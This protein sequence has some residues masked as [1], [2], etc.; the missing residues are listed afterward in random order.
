MHYFSYYGQLSSDFGLV[1]SEKNIYSAPQRDMEFVSVP[2]RN[3]DILIDH[4]RF[5]NLEV[6]YTVS[7]K[8]AKEKAPAIRQW[9]TGHTGYTGLMDSYQPGYFRIASYASKLD[10]QE[11]IEN[12]GTAKIVFNCKP[13]RYRLDG[14]SGITVTESG[15]SLTNPEAYASEP[16]I[17]VYG[18]GDIAIHINRE[19]YAIKDA[20]N[21]MILNS[22]LMSVHKGSILLNDHI[23][24]S[25][26]PT[27]APGENMIQWSGNVT[28]LIITPNWRCL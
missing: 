26:F 8:N 24:F 7:F 27:L 16:Q 15:T 20:V 13:F 17:M 5:Q 9:L 6:S 2:G 10:I 1:I 25:E 19:T 23:N 11:L 21:G 22:E 28:K 14:I 18:S 4:G 12:V 3:G